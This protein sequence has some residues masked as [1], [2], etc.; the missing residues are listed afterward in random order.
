MRQAW[1]YRY[2]HHPSLLSI[3]KLNEIADVVA[4]VHSRLEKGTR[5]LGGVVRRRQAQNVAVRYAG[6]EVL[7]LG[8]HARRDGHVVKLL[9]RGHVEMRKMVLSDSAV[10]C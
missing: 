3:I 7:P 4:P 9:R 2:P 6:D 1:L 8:T 5:R 10:S